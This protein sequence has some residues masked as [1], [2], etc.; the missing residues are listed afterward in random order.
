MR[1]FGFRTLRLPFTI[2]TYTDQKLQFIIHKIETM[3]HSIMD[4][5]EDIKYHIN[6][7]QYFAANH[8]DNKVMDKVE[9][10]VNQN[11]LSVHKKMYPFSWG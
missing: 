6:W 4:E 1:L 9:L 5:F 2:R 10:A 8:N 11:G 3:V 7:L